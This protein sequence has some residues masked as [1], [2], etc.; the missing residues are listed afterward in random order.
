MEGRLHL[1]AQAELLQG[2]QVVFEGMVVT[3]IM[4]EG[5]EGLVV[6]DGVVPVQER[7]AGEIEV[8]VA[9]HER[10]RSP[11][12]DLQQQPARI[13]QL[14]QTAERLRDV[15][16]VLDHVHAR[17]EV[18]RS[19]T[20]GEAVVED[21]ARI[22]AV[23]QSVIQ[24]VGLGERDR[25]L[26]C[27]QTTRLPEWPRTPSHR[28]RDGLRKTSDDTVEVRSGPR[29]ADDRRGRFTGPERGAPS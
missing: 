27:R 25:R 15:Q 1:T 12:G 10:E 11:V 17:D 7:D 16:N 2:S 5:E 9:R 23:L 3:D 19:R 22:D 28:R 24:A 21:A 6:S 26:T 8:A 29:K 20:G 13:Q 14:G 4:G 18:E